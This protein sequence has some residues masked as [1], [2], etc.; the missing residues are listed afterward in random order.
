MG[1]RPVSLA[2]GVV[3]GLT[4]LVGLAYGGNDAPPA[5]S[6]ASSAP[7]ALLDLSIRGRALGISA[8]PVTAPTLG[9]APGRA[10]T[11]A[12]SLRMPSATTQLGRGVYV[13][14]SPTCIPGVD[15]FPVPGRRGRR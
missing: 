15:D 12:G 6:A 2:A 1:T 8:D 10:P 7:D 11:G 9:L 3:V 4:I 14:V 5:G 13:S